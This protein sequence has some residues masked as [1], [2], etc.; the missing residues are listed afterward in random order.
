MSR[1]AGMV[2]A[3]VLLALGS[4]VA[5]CTAVPTPPWLRTGCFNSSTAEQADFDFNGVPNELGNVRVFGASPI[6][7][8]TDGTCS[9]DLILTS[10]MVRAS[11]QE[12]A[13]TICD[14]LGAPRSVFGPT[15]LL[16][17]GYI[18]P[19]DAWGC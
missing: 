15:Q 11:T 17:L 16:T 6:A 1:C 13:Q 3:V 19:L 12:G 8:S 5:A 2:G 4:G 18:I 7:P 14:S 9:G 10:T